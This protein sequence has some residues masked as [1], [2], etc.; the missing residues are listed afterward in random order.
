MKF[1]KIKPQLIFKPS[2]FLGAIALTTLLVLS[3][4]QKDDYPSYETGSLLDSFSPELKR[5][6]S[7][8]DMDHDIRFMLHHYKPTDDFTLVNGFDRKKHE[9]FKLLIN[10]KEILFH[11]NP[12]ALDGESAKFAK[13]FYGKKNKIT[14]ILNDKKKLEYDFEFPEEVNIEIST[15]GLITPN[16]T[17][18]NWQPDKE[19]MVG[20]VVEHIKK[21]S[22][23]GTLKNILNYDIIRNSGKYI[24]P[25]KLFDN[26]PN[27]G[28]VSVKLIQGNYLTDTKNSVK[29]I[30]F[31]LDYLTLPYIQNK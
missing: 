25:E 14:Y 2:L 31:S 20:I 12:Y 28:K 26:I 6:E 5:F 10:D 13:D 24:I 9:N 17:V 29:L 11:E 30:A 3:A 15:P 21:D 7:I 16:K 8:F 1:K 22:E 4:C 19:A 18:L 27:G 23:S